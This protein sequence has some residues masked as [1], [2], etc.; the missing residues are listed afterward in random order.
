MTAHIICILKVFYSLTNQ[1]CNYRRCLEAKVSHSQGDEIMGTLILHYCTHC[2]FFY[3][4]I[5]PTCSYAISSIQISQEEAWE[6]ITEPFFPSPFPPF[7]LSSLSRRQNPQ[8]SFP[9]GPVGQAC[10]C[11]HDTVPQQ[12]GMAC[13]C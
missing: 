2:H 11:S 4:M 1:I 8:S 3:K 12:A 6:Q 9:Q 13:Y 5:N 10:L 7:S